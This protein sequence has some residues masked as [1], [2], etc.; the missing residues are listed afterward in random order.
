MGRGRK[1][2]FGVSGAMAAG[3]FG[4]AAVHGE[5]AADPKALTQAYNVSGQQLFRELAATPGN[6]VLSPYSIGSAMAMALAGARGAT[7]TE[8]LTVLKHRLGREEI[9]AANTGVLAILNGYD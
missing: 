6:I 2:A 9:D 3:L 4:L 7:E 8:M 5:A 1:W